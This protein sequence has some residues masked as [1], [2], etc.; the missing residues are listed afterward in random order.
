MGDL[1]D[2]LEAARHFNSIGQQR[3]QHLLVSVIVVGQANSVV[4]FYLK[5][6]ILV[7]FLELG[8]SYKSVLHEHKFVATIIFDRDVYANLRP[9][10]DVIR[11]ISLE[12]LNLSDG[13]FD[14]READL[15]IE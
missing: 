6:L 1:S 12:L 4:F 14:C 3:L 9:L 15:F 13:H 8:G 5:F 2:G 11:K 10:V 7:V